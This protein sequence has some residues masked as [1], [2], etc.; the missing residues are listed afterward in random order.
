MLLYEEVM[1]IAFRKDYRVVGWQTL[2]KLLFFCILMFMDV[3]P[4]KTCISAIS[5]A[6]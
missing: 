4:F 6:E 2:W 3:L 1:K 5:Q